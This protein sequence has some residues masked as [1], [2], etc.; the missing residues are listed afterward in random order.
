VCPCSSKQ[1]AGGNTAAYFAARGVQL[2]PDEAAELVRLILRLAD[3]GAV[4]GRADARAGY[5][6][7]QGVRSTRGRGTSEALADGGSD[8]CG[9][10]GLEGPTV[11]NMGPS[12]HGDSR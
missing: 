6:R 1:Q 9:R 7:P 4:C 3:L 10:V 2:S 8:G 12:V 5:D 11:Y